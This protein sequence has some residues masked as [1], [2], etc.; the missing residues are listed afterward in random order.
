MNTQSQNKGSGL[1]NNLPLQ[2]G[3]LAVAVVIVLVIAARYL[4]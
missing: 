1:A 3:L 4:W 2:L